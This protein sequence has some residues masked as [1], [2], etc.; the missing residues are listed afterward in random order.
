MYIYMYI[1]I[2]NYESQY[3]FMSQVVDAAQTI[4]G[5]IYLR[6]KKHSINDNVFFYHHHKH[7]CANPTTPQ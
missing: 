2:Y 1:Y 7:I 4:M 6:F 5:V 3:V